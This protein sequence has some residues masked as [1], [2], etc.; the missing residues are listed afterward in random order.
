MQKHTPLLLLLLLASCASPPPPPPPPAPEPPPEPVFEFPYTQVWT[1]GPSTVL[2]T[3]S[4]GAI[5]VPRPFTRLEVLQADT[6]G[7]LVRCNRCERVV[8]GRVDWDAVVFAPQDPATAA[9]GTISE[10]AL[11]IRRSAESRDLDALRQVMAR[12]FT[13]ALIGPTGP[14]AAIAG[15]EAE[16]FAALEMVPEL[17]DRGLATRDETLWAAPAEHL[18]ELGYRGYR[19]GFRARADGRWE[20]SFLVRGER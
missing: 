17:L 1:A 2:H 12:D 5:D 9:H 13:Y 6:A 11:A 7:A 4:A 18:E 15:W 8:E 14:E 16:G 10:F 20:W 19:L 3:D